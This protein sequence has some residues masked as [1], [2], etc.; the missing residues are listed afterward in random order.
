MEGPN[1]ESG[2]FDYEVAG[3]FIK[4]PRAAVHGVDVTDFG[5]SPDSVT[6]VFS[7]DYRVRLLILRRRICGASATRHHHVCL[8]NSAFRAESF[9]NP[10]HLARHVYR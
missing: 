7:G 3:I 1:G 2:L 4:I 5:H 10:F 6:Q 8:F 9:G